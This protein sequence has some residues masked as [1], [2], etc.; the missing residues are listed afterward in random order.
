MNPKFEAVSERYSAANPRSQALFERVRKVMPGGVKG[1]YYYPP[2]PLSLERGEGQYLWDVDGH[3]Y[4]DL[5]NHHTAQV[6]GHNH[7]AVVAAIASQVKRGVALGASMGN[8]V[9]M[10]E[11]MCRRVASL[12]SIRFCNSGTEATLHAVRLAREFSGRPKIAK[13]EGGYH[14]NHDGVEISVA[15]PLDRAGPRGG[16]GGGARGRGHGPQRRRCGRHPTLRRRGRGG[17]DRRR[18]RRRAGLHHARPQGRRHAAAAGVRPRC[19]GDRE[20][21][22]PHPPVRRDRRFPR[23]HRGIQE[24]FGIRPDLSTYGKIVGGGFPVGAFGGRRDIMDLTDNSA[25]PA[26]VFQSGTHSGHALAMAAGRATLDQL[27]PEAFAHVNGLTERLCRGVERELERA[28][29]PGRAVRD[30]SAFS[31]YFSA[32][33]PRSYRSLARCD[34]ELNAPV[35]LSLLN[36]GYFLSHA[37]GMNAVSLP[38]QA[39]DV[40]GFVEAFGRALAEVG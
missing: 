3:R 38:T 23:R 22:R 16:A 30:G 8:E 7:P 31:I 2:F 12:D 28:G 27:T 24:Q 9:E 35:F 40:D 26:R 5:A 29:I 6:L 4:L 19:R 17:G 13:F 25:G 14:G 1:A 36:Q 21:A 37:L 32:A 18:P 33:Q 20:K 34:K 10:A 39:A 15:P 11:E